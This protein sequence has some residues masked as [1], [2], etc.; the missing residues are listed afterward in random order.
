MDLEARSLGSLEAPHCKNLMHFQ[1]G[2]GGTFNREFIGTTR[3][4]G[5]LEA[6]HFKNSRYFSVLNIMIIG[7]K[8]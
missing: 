7:P 5:T 1:Y 8:I 2:F 3:S 6:R 4:L